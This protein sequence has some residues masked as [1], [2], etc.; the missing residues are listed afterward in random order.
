MARGAAFLFEVA[1]RY[2][3]EPERVAVQGHTAGGH[4]ALLVAGRR[5]GA[6]GESELGRGEPLPFRGA[7][8]LAGVV[9]LRLAWELGLS[10]RAV[11]GLLL[12]GT[13]GT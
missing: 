13:G 9:D 6:P 4:L 7:V 2:G 5:P 1:H 10:E 8:S 12:F 3:I 11:G